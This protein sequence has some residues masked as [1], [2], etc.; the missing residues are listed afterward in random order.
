MLHHSYSEH[1]AKMLDLLCTTVF[2]DKRG[3]YR[4]GVHYPE[5]GS[6]YKTRGDC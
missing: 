3:K 6:T 2:K 4:L 5:S 1:E